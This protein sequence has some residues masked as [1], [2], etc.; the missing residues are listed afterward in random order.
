[1]W[2]FMPPLTEERREFVK[3]ANVEGEH[4][5]VAIRNIRRDAIE[6]ISDVK[7]GA[8]RRHHQRR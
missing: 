7:G 3:K 4:S 2:L 6:H 5:K 8:K 1:M